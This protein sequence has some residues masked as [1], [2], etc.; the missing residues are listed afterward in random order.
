MKKEEANEMI[1][2]L[3][4]NGV[5]NIKI[6]TVF[7][8]G[9]SGGQKRRVSIGV[10]IIS[11]PKIIFLDEPTS[12]L[13]SAAAY[14]VMVFLKKFAKQGHSVVCT[15]HQP[16]SQVF[17]MID[18]VLLLSGGETAYYGRVGEMVPYLGSLGYQ[19]PE[20]LNPSDY[21][22]EKINA[23]FGNAE[24]AKELI[25]AWADNEVSEKDDAPVGKVSN[26]SPS[27]SKETLKFKTSFFVQMYYLFMRMMK[28]NVRNPGV[29]WVRLFM[30][31]C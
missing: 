11:K 6:G 18:R 1:A 3:G 29:Y 17:H 24:S 14:K 7:Q 28:D 4:L 23:D 13:D 22:M 21:V 2:Q 31:S 26:I 20:Y 12:G 10:E 25:A 30:Y 27:S 8:K 9:I 19:C 16:S 15:I 5:A